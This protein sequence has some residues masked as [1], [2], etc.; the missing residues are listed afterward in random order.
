MKIKCGCKFWA[1]K[2]I[3]IIRQTK[4]DSRAAWGFG[5]I[6]SSV[7]HWKI[8]MPPLVLLVLNRQAQ[9]TKQAFQRLTMQNWLLLSF[10]S[11]ATALWFAYDLASGEKS[12][13]LS[14]L[15]SNLMT[16]ISHKRRDFTQRLSLEQLDGLKFKFP[17][18]RAFSK[19]PHHKLYQCTG[20]KERGKSYPVKYKK[21]LSI[22][23]LQKVIGV[24]FS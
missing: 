22:Q 20:H 24:Y 1:L 8:Q 21:T 18:S 9:R 12:N 13:T 10:P 2:C 11:G 17:V 4:I 19:A 3:V 15:A 7:F 6:D 5:T 23:L 14:I 16:Y